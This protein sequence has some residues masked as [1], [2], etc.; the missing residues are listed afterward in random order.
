MAEI[1]RPLFAQASKY[2][3]RVC[4]M[5][6][7]VTASA[8]YALEAQPKRATSIEGRWL[9]NSAQSDDPERMLQERH[10][11]ER[12]KFRRAM[13]RVQRSPAQLPPI[14]E[15]G[16]EVPVRSTAA[17]DRVSRRQ[18]REMQLMRRMLAISPTLQVK[19]D[20]VRIEMV[21]IVESRRFEA[22]TS[23][24]VSMPEG[25]LAEL[26]VGWKGETFIVERVTRRGPRVTEEFRLLPKTDQLEYRMVWR[27]ET[28]LSGM[29]I[30][31]VYDRDTRPA[32]IGTPNVGPMR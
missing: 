11:R 31:R 3:A 8:A 17:R 7:L 20:G 5:L 4:V 26:T 14:G 32:P 27:G 23:S 13:E 18:E 25:Q 19:Q 24:H 21:T 1:V 22:G 30:R 15:E 6:W 12:E 2:V 16:V 28:E 10:E 9:I 29:K